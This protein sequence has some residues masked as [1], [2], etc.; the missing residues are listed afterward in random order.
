MTLN[1]TAILV[2]V[3]SYLILISISKICGAGK[4]AHGNFELETRATQ[5]W[6]NWG[7]IDGSLGNKQYAY[8]V[9]TNKFIFHSQC[10]KEDRT[11]AH[12][13]QQKSESNVDGLINLHAKVHFYT[14]KFWLSFWSYISSLMSGLWLRD[15]RIVI[16]FNIS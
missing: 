2:Q 7:N 9:C 4:R 6:N 1:S 15:S 14:L 10:R 11:G 8:S 16:M 12:C 13:T 5:C 3:L